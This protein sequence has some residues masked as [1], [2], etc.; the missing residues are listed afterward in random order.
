MRRGRCASA[1]GLATPR[2]PRARGG[3]TG[4]WRGLGLPAPGITAPLS[5]R[6]AT[7]ARPRADAWLGPGT[8]PRAPPLRLGDRRE[9]GAAA[10][11]ESAR[12]RA[13]GPATSGVP[14]AQRP[15]RARVNAQRRPRAN[16]PRRPESEVPGGA[17]GARGSELGADPRLPL[18]AAT[19]R[20]GVFPHRA[21]RPSPTEFEA[22]TR[23]GTPPL[24]RGVSTAV[25]VLPRRIIFGFLAPQLSRAVTEP[26]ATRRPHPREGRRPA[27]GLRS[28]GGGPCQEP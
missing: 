15:Q 8:R 20:L 11:P 25:R 23:L 13:P 27:G 1:P 18:D 7:A 9:G 12:R 3:G 24:C 17:P 22:Q 14:R 4:A 26:E 10:G 16:S 6:P 5:A 21:P 28:R 19:S 2:A